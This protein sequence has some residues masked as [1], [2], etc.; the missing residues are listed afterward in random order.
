MMIVHWVQ[1]KKLSGKGKSSAAGSSE[2]SD[3]NC[4]LR[5]ARIPQFSLKNVLIL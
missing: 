4:L 3:A 5:Y 1:A 2:E